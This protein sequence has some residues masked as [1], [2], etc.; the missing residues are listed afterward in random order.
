MLNWEIP[1][2]EAYHFMKKYNNSEYKKIERHYYDIHNKVIG[3]HS[4]EDLDRYE[5]IL[6]NNRTKKTYL[7]T[8]EDKEWMKELSFNNMVYPNSNDTEGVIISNYTIE[9]LLSQYP[10]KPE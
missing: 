10:E 5:E 6:E 9:S 2:E 3:F 1:S 7:I 8:W 4:Q